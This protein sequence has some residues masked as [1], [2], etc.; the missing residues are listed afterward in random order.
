VKAV[1]FEQIES[2]NLQG[3]AFGYAVTG[4]SKIERAK[5]QIQARPQTT[6]LLLSVHDLAIGKI[7]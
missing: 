5:V 6:H 3:M 4:Y 1:P 2:L 7:R